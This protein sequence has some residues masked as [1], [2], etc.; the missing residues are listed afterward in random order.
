MSM[1]QPGMLSPSKAQ[2]GNYWNPTP[3]SGYT[4]LGALPYGSY[5][6][7]FMLHAYRPSAAAAN[8][9]SY[10]CAERVQ[11]PF[12]AYPPSPPQSQ[13]SELYYPLTSHGWVGCRR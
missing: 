12:A 7:K 5:Y 3:A 10:S 4:L 1:C 13:I 2:N 9:Q 6:S 11:Q 8:M